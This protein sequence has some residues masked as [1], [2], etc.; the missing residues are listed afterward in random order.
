MSERSSNTTT[1]NNNWS[2]CQFWTNAS[3]K[4]AKWYGVHRGAEGSGVYQEWEDVKRVTKGFSM[5]C[6]RVFSRKEDAEHF[7]ATG[8]LRD[9][10][11]PTIPAGAVGCWI[12]GSCRLV[13]DP[14]HWAAGVGVFFGLECPFNYRGSFDIPP[15]TNQRAE[16]WAAIKAIEIANEQPKLIPKERLLVIHSDSSY[17][18]QAVN[19]WIPQQWLRNNWRGGTIKNRALFERLWRLVQGRSVRFVHVLGHKGDRNNEA[20][21][22]LAVMGAMWGNRSMDEGIPQ[23][24][25]QMRQAMAKVERGSRLQTKILY[26][27]TTPQQQQQQGDGVI[28]STTTDAGV[29]LASTPAAAAGGGGP[30]GGPGG[31]ELSHPAQQQQPH[32]TPSV[33]VPSVPSVAS[34]PDSI[35]RGCGFNWADDVLGCSSHHDGGGTCSDRLLGH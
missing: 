22:G 7:A 4:D 34:L 2:S 19:E 9:V 24:R 26:Q 6:Y 17:L 35:D 5:P 23:M 1:N 21:D 27:D 29:S 30:G 18:V 8:E 10:A 16:I 33:S 32:Q 14:A 31:G 3:Q 20:A 13:G 12:D 25:Q 15:L 28:A 11:L